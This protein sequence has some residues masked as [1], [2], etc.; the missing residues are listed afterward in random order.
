MSKTYIILPDQHAHSD[1]HN[2]RAIWAGQLIKEIR[3]DVVVNM[4]DCIDLPSLS[5]YDKGK[6]SFHGRSYKSDL[7][8]HLDFQDKLWSP[9]KRAKKK[10]PRRIVLEGNHEHRI[11][12]ALDLSPE[13]TGTLGFKDFLFDEYYDDVVR[14]EGGTP[15][16]FELD[17]ILFAHYFITGVSGKPIS[18]EHPAYA[19]LIKNGCSSIAAHTHLFDY[20]TRTNIQGKTMNSI[21]AGCYQD[22]INDWSGN[23]GRL[24]RSGI[25]VLRNVEAGDFDVQFISIGAL[26]KEYGN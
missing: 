18:S 20:T 4:G 19:H 17:Q 11:E 7:D 25:T 1:H 3:P 21:V 14:Y 10:L 9:T 23:I 5:S 6:R 13:L 2:D 16:V 26:K 15:G 8:A 12:R 22:Y 24:W